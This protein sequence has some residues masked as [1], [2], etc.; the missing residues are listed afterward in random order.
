MGVIK[1]IDLDLIGILG[2]SL[3][4]AMGNRRLTNGK[5]E[6]ECYRVLIQATLG[7]LILEVCSS[8]VAAS[9][10]TVL[11][12]LHKLINVLGF[13][14]VPFVGYLWIE[15]I[16]K[17]L[18]LKYKMNLFKVPIWIN[19]FITILS[20]HYPLIFII[21]SKN[22]YV[23]GPWF[24]V[25]IVISYGYMGLAILIILK[26]RRQLDNTEIKIMGC[27]SSAPL[28]GMF[29]QVKVPYMQCVW[30][31][32]AMCLVGYYIYLQDC[33]LR[34]DSLT[35]AWSRIAFED[36]I[37]NELFNRQEFGLISIDL[38]GFKQ[39]NDTYG[40]QEG[41]EA[42]KIAVHILKEGVKKRGKVARIG[43]D[44]FL[45]IIEN[46]KGSNMEHVIKDIDRAVKRYND[47]HIKP[48][49]LKWSI[50]YEIYN[51]QYAQ[52]EELLSYIDERMYLEKRSKKIYKK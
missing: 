20:Y 48:Y 37:Q 22:A 18:H 27:F 51:G 24:F 30:A 32:V 28:I 38:D 44:E 6:N 25:P 39:I 33:S 19:G 34:Y 52:I 11:I 12:P 2:L 21:N 42:L 46:V 17:H 29:I 7:V 9:R 50:G 14:I 1:V 26:H 35:N 45:V 15:Y 16:I 47:Q 40:H 10:S 3:L 41:D 8:I 23:R 4:L 5:R 43:G 49:Q 13:G 36:Y 31:F